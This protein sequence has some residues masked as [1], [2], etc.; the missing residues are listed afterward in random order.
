MQAIDTNTVVRHL[1]G[2]EP[3][4][5]ARARTVTDAGDVFASTTVL[6]ES[7]WVL[8][9]VYGFSYQ[10]NSLGFPGQVL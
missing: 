9:S 7:K 10:A 3:K 4:Q 6:L 5:A 2:D 1:T 8:R